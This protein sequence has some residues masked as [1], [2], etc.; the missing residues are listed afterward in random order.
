MDKRA[1][2]TGTVRGVRGGRRGTRALPEAPPTGQVAETAG[3]PFQGVETRQERETAAGRVKW[4]ARY[5][6][7][8]GFTGTIYQHRDLKHAI[9]VSEHD[10]FC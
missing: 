8:A 2:K 3:D 5:F 10:H 4:S 6:D 7:I 1:K 9:S